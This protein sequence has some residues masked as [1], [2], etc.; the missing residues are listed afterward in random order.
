[1][2]NA[3][4]CGGP[5][6]RLRS[7]ACINDEHNFACEGSGARRTSLPEWFSLDAGLAGEQ[8]CNR[9]GSCSPRRSGL[10]GQRLACASR[11]GSPATAEVPLAMELWLAEV[12]RWP[13]RSRC[14]GQLLQAAACS[15]C[16]DEARVPLH[17]CFQNFR[18]R[19]QLSLF[20]KVSSDARR[21]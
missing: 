14:L 9:E 13:R 16:K 2:T 15:T 20:M 3:T 1:M 19:L 5:E 7:L 11:G 8:F 10:V 4:W 12:R 21:Y 6:R 18:H 17:S